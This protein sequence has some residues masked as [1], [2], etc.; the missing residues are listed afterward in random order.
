[1]EGKWDEVFKYLSEGIYPS[2]YN[3]SQKLNLRRYSEKFNLKDGEL[4]FGE[5]KAIKTSADAKTIFNEF[6][7]SPIGGHT[8]MVKTR[9]AISARF[10][11]KG[12]SVDIDTWV[13]ECDKCQRVGQAKAASKPLPCI[14]VSA[15]WELL[16][17]DL[18][19]PLPK[20]ANGFQYI[21]TA[22]DYYSKW[23]EAFPLRSKTAA[24][25]GRHVCSLIY[26]HGCPKR[27]L[28]DQGRK[29]VNELNS[30]LCE[31]LGIDRSVTAAYHPQA[32]GLDETTN[33][34][35][36]RVLT[37]LVNERQ[38]NWDVFLEATLFSLRSTVHITT[39]KTPFLLL[40]G[41]EPVFPSE[42]PVDMPRELGDMKQ[43]S[44][45]RIQQREKEA[46]ELRQAIFSLTR[47]A[48]ATAEEC[49]AI[50]TEMIRSMELKRFEVREL[51][52]AQEKMAITEAEQLLE[53]IQKEITELKKNEA[54]LDQLSR[55]EDPVHFLQSCESL[56]APAA[57]SASPS[58]S[59]DPGL[60]FGPVMTAVADFKGLL[61]EVCQGGFVSIYE[62][63]RAIT[64]VGP[65]NAAAQ[66]NTMLVGQTV[67]AKLTESPTP[68]PPLGLDQTPVSPLSPLNPLNPFLSPGPSVPTFNFSPFGSKLSSG[69]R[70]RHLQRRPI[71]KR[72]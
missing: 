71:S 13:L 3:K 64:I 59:A 5:R 62:R 4:F 2:G 47:S 58:L 40:Y 70:P 8:G 28:S 9:H 66:C 17:I 63:V 60:S 10:Y 49:D 53:K 32:N 26:R 55:T 18:T 31:M 15:V 43:S 37:Q 1:M 23:V 41:R 61:Q 25:V 34:N 39:K 33:H 42:V 30:S 20:T 46:Q 16:G 67:S 35:I 57:L 44:Q 51:I 29:F 36:N 45:F 68:D 11:W 54:E 27:I 14:K 56:H 12:M 69:S 19:G 38:D 22:T 72:K 7:N 52:K 50:F 24:E 21:L 48:R 6:H 65:Q